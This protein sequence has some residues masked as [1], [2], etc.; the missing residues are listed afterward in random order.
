M[1]QILKFAFPMILTH[2]G[3]HLMGFVDLYFVGR[4]SSVQTGAVG[5]G[6]SVW[7]W[8]LLFGIGLMAGLEYLAAMA[9]GEKDYKK[10]HEYLTQALVLS[11][12]LALSFTLILYVGT[13]FYSTF[14]I[15]PEVIGPAT[16]YTRLVAW[17][18]LPTYWFYI[19]RIYL[20]L[21]GKA[22]YPIVVLLIGNILNGFMDYFFIFGKVGTQIYGAT[23]VAW[24][25]LIS[26]IFMASALIICWLYWDR[27]GN[28]YFFKYPWRIY[29]ARMQTV[30]QAGLPI[31]LRMV[32]ESGVFAVS[33]MLAARFSPRELAIH[34]IALNLI[35]MVF[36]FPLGLSSAIAILMGQAFGQ[37]KA[38][39][40]LEFG[41]IGFSFGTKIG[42]LIGLVFLIFAEPILSLFTKDLYVIQA[43]KKVVWLAAFHQL[44]DGIQIIGVGALRGLGNTR[45]PMIYHLIGNWFIGFPCSL[46]F[47]FS[48]LQGVEGL[49]IGLTIGTASVTL[50][51]YLK[52]KQQAA[53]Y[54]N[55]C[56]T[57]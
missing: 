11:L 8:F 2:F 24:A 22:Y 27:K 39:E 36:L 23:G 15:H 52:W 12:I 31:A 16:S 35:S 19:F 44:L 49:W 28:R 5:V 38:A 6:T 47:S 10:Q 32:F 41:R 17:S 57:D 4:V 20:T 37:K 33:V 56:S 21:I 7:I 53:T 13:N 46:F 30:I 40:A 18:L 42:I 51:T 29:K 48:R 9:Y 54:S 25:T 3:T 1:K 34:E 55:L 43:G 45:D 50:A 14:K 26:R